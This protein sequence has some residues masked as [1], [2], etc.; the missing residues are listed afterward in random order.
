MKF[1]ITAICLL[2]GALNTFASTTAAQFLNLGFGAKA[3]SMADSFVSYTDDISAGFYNPSS[4]GNK[5]EKKEWLVSHS[6]HIQDTSISQFAYKNNNYGFMIDYF[7]AGDIEGRGENKEVTGDFSVYDLMIGGGYGFRYSDLLLGF[8]IKFVQQKIEDSKGNALASDIGMIY[9]F[10]DKP[11][12]FG[13]SLNNFG[14]K[15]KMNSSSYSLPLNLKT[16]VSY[17]I[18]GKNPFV[19]SVEF[20]IPRYYTSSLRIGSEYIFRSFALRAG[21]KSSKSVERDA[22]TGDSSGIDELY[23]FYFGFGIKI[24]GIDL[25]YALLPYGELGKSHRFAISGRF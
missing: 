5:S 19:L 21:W 13:I 23:G 12:V 22:I 2:Y 4:W 20:D 11:I 1:L 24:L 3:P 6:W 16:G 10:K 18:E 14:T 9:D 7:S 25:D 17:H 8:N 15:I